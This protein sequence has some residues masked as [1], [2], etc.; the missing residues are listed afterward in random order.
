MTENEWRRM[1]FRAQI[2]HEQIVEALLD[3]D[4]A[5]AEVLMREHANVAK[6]S[7]RILADAQTDAPDTELGLRLVAT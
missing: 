4:A 3:A 5:R 1:I 7:V 2:E 6:D